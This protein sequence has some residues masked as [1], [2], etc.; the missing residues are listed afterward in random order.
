LAKTNQGQ[1]PI[2]RIRRL[3]GV[4]TYKAPRIH[5][6]QGEAA[7]SVRLEFYVAP[8]GS[9]TNA[10]TIEAPFATL[11]RARDAVRE[12]LRA[13]QAAAET[14]EPPVKEPAPEPIS[15]WVRGGKYYLNETLALSAEDSGTAQAPVVFAAY[16]GEEPVLSGGVAI[17][18]WTAHRGKILQAKLPQGKADSWD[19]RQLFLDGKRQ[20]RARFPNADPEDPWRG[21]LLQVEGAAE[22]HSVTAF[23]YREGS[24]PR[25]W[26]RPTQGEVVMIVDWGY[27]TICAIARHEPEDRCITLAQGV[28][29]FGQRQPWFG[30][31][32]SWFG[33]SVPYR[34]HVENLLEELDTPGEWC[35]DTAAGR[36]YFWPPDELSDRSEVSVPALDCLIDLS[37]A[38][39]V[40]L[41][42]FTFT[43]TRNAGSNMHR[44]GYHGA[45][46]M[47]PE[48]GYGYCG[49]AVHLQQSEHCRISN[50][51]FIAVGGNAIYVEGYGLKNVVQGNEIAH[52]GSCGI[53]VV[54]AKDRKDEVRMPIGTEIADNHIHHCGEFDKVAP[55]VFCGASI[56]TAIRHN[57]IEYMPHHG[58]NLGASGYGGNLVEYNRLRYCC[59]RNYD[60]GVINCWMEDN[61]DPGGDE[62]LLIE[63]DA[64]RSG[65]VFRY[66]HISDTSGRRQAADTHSC[67]IGIYQDSHTSNC[68]VYGN[69]VECNQYRAIRVNGG[70]NNIIENNIVVDCGDEEGSLTLSNPGDWPI[71][72]QM[73]G[74]MIANRFCRNI[75]VTKGLAPM[76]VIQIHDSPQD[77]PRVLAESDYNLFFN[78]DGDGYAIRLTGSGGPSTLPFS[79]WQRMGNDVHS[80]IADPMFVDPEQGDYRLKPQ[81]PALG[82]GFQPIDLSRIGIRSEQFL[83]RQ[84]G[85]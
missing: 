61:T 68:E 57:Q 16:P 29:N 54:G 81:S 62:A 32:P 58:I 66:N 47:Y 56:G 48:P 10:G 31:Q 4:S 5:H 63:R 19:H 17:G 55:G 42:G 79:E 44:A 69:I 12:M 26:T 71:W 11:A 22:E 23:R 33:I 2:A 30:F 6:E 37:G 64:A 83:C 40:T 70:R 45:G 84:H 52:A 67:T 80:L 74:F 60:I 53:G 76:P 49:E 73:K 9:D 75:C 8:N 20:V 72:P 34:F 7:M 46:A 65:H 41:E 51:R 38:R 82:L 3:L 78:G 24:F 77:I 59:M 36:I 28:R 25:P 43:E 21:G 15:V 39:W 35:V 1:Y 13:R 50:S 14:L 18:G 27:T 85:R